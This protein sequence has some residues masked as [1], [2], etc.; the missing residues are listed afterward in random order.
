MLL[1]RQTSIVDKDE[2]MREL[3]TKFEEL[4]KSDD[5]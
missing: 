1:R 4:F 2:L 5:E 3:E